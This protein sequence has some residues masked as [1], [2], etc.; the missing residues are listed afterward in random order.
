MRNSTGALFFFA[1]SLS[2]AVG[3]DDEVH[4]G[5]G[6][7]DG[8]PRCPATGC[9][10]GLLGNTARIGGHPLSN[11]SETLREPAAND[12]ADVRIEGGTAEHLGSTLAITE[13]DVE[14]DGELR[15]KLGAAGWIGGT[16]VEGA[17]FSITV[18]PLSGDPTFAAEL[19]VGGA[20]CSP[21]EYDPTLTICRYEFVTNVVPHD[22]QRYPESEELAGY[23]HTCPNEDEGGALGDTYEFSAVLSPNVSVFASAS[24]G[25]YITDAPGR[26]IHGCI[27]GAV[28]KGQF[29]L[30]AF[31]DP[32]AYR[33]LQVTQR[34]AMLRAWLAWF[35][36]E[37]RTVP[38]KQVALHDPLG[39]LFTWPADPTWVL[40]AGY[41][42]SGARCRGGS[43]A[44]GVHRH[45]L[46]PVQSLPGWSTLPPCTTA[47]YAGSGAVL[48]VAVP[49]DL[50]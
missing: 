12:T 1:S 42:A 37:P 38:G 14:A 18:D 39:G 9:A 29:H 44:T 10:G 46:D 2:V 6:D 24:L 45:H 11:L 33:G 8:V 34:T 50:W 16:A 36:G 49:G 22:P 31:Y 27:N 23:Y 48:G 28:A 15:L 32:T 7:G 4:A 21:G 19:K 43:P 41:G 47:D 13:I 25:P 35:A 17:T 5:A 3:C 40:E 20:W 30:N 26:F